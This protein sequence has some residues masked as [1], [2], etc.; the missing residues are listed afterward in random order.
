MQSVKEPNHLQFCIQIYR[1]R[2]V[3]EK[4]EI[5]VILEHFIFP[6]K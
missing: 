4:N 1:R 6:L 5:S 3:G 2:R